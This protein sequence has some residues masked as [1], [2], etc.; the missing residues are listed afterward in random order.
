MSIS[1]EPKETLDVRGDAVK[2]SNHLMIDDAMLDRLELSIL[3]QGS[4]TSKQ[5]A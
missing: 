4:A 5:E 3:K 1:Q 2:T